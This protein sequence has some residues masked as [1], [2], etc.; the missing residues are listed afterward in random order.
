MKHNN[1]FLNNINGFF[2]TKWEDILV[3]PSK[4]EF[5][6]GTLKT[7]GAQLTCFIFVKYYIGIARCRKF[8]PILNIFLPWLKNELKINQLAYS[9]N[10]KVS[11]LDNTLR[12]EALLAL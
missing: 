12:L 2:I 8:I 6:F 3:I 11:Y 10:S 5:M 9:Q 7:F 1:C 4:K